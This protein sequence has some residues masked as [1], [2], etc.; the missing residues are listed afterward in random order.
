MNNREL[1]L[2]TIDKLI[3]AG[4]YENFA[5]L[6]LK[7]N[8]YIQ[9]AAAIGDKEVYCEAVSDNFL[10]QKL[11]KIQIKTLEN[12]GWN[13]PED[14]QSNYSL[15]LPAD[16]KEAIFDLADFILKTA[17]TAYNTENIEKRNLELNLV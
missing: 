12:L 14:A 8:C 3:N 9:L 17:Q 2:F 11:S 5:I 7:K 15:T 6:A 16:S 4:N 1:I 10:K 13:A